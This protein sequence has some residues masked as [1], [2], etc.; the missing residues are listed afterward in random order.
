MK[1]HLKSKTSDFALACYL[2]PTISSEIKLLSPQLGITQLHWRIVLLSTGASSQPFPAATGQ[3]DDWHDLLCIYGPSRLSLPPF[4]FG[5]VTRA[6]GF[7][8]TRGQY[9]HIMHPFISI[10][11]LTSSFKLF[12]NVMNPFC[13]YSALHFADHLLS[14]CCHHFFPGHPFSA[15]LNVMSEVCMYIIPSGVIGWSSMSSLTLGPE[16]SR[17]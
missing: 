7:M 11:V 6:S 9:P 5:S 2:N 12:T 15:I 16:P 3:L 13:W 17:F 10:S 8:K 1:I 14:V 4:S